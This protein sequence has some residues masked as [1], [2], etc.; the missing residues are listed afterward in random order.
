M[1][2]SELKAYSK[3]I[4]VEQFGL[5]NAE[6]QTDM[7]S[8]Y[9]TDHGI[10][11]TIPLDPSKFSA[12]QPEVYKDIV[13]SYYRYGIDE[14]PEVILHKGR[15]YIVDGT[16]RICSAILKKSPTIDVILYKRL[17]GS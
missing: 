14:P 6:E 1:R 16:H 12:V 3:E 8:G 10:E 9:D 5:E 17:S 15:Y 13:Q 4:P 7:L 11:K 2:A